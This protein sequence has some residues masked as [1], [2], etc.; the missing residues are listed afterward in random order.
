MSDTAVLSNEVVMVR[1]TMAGPTVYFQPTTNQ[2]VEWQGAGDP[3]GGDV[4]PIPIAMFNEV[5]FQRSVQRGIYERVADDYDAVIKAHRE[6]WQ[7]AE[8]RRKNASLDNLEALS[9]NDIHTYTCVAPKGRA[10][11]GITCDVS[12]PMTPK[13]HSEKPPLCVEHKADAVKF[14]SEETDEFEA[15]KPKVKWK[16]VQ[17]GAR[18]RQQS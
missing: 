3:H 14:V 5:Q 11:S 8:D 9:Q 16:R 6:E 1:N 17:L 10:N 13:E 18:E 15:G 2:Q 12:V 4:Q 7:Q